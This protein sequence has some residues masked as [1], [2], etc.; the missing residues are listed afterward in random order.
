MKRLGYGIL[1]ALFC[2]LPA[3]VGQNFDKEMPFELVQVPEFTG[4]DKALSR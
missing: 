2:A 1:T 3:P 4:L